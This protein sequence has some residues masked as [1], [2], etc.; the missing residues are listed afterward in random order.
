MTSYRITTVRR[1]GIPTTLKIRLDAFSLKNTF[2][3]WDEASEDPDVVWVGWFE[4]GQLVK[5]MMARA[6]A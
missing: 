3:A 1:D 5:T 4:N 2:K 6:M